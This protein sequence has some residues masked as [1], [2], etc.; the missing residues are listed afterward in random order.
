MW[1]RFPEPAIL[2][3]PPTQEPAVSDA[4]QPIR[5]LLAGYQAAVLA[6]DVDAFVALYADDALIYELWGT[7]T[8]DIASWRA[9]AKGW[10]EFLGDQKSVVEAHDVKV[11]VSGDMALLTAFLT[12]HA[13]DASGQE[14][15]SLDN[16]L[17]WVA[18]RRGGRWQVVHEHTSVPIAHA[19][20]KGMFKRP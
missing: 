5:Q 12:Y 1:N 2:R 18:R 10:F 3:A 9:M 15:R 13:V 7:W 8:H 11:D 20:G 6:K 17:S 16:R 4:D 19:D 14:L